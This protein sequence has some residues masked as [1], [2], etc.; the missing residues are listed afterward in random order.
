[1]LDGTR[2]RVLVY[3]VVMARRKP[4]TQPTGIIDVI[5][6]IVSPWLGTPPG[7]YSSVTQAQGL[8]R[9]AAETLDQTFA[10]GMIKAGVQGNKALA[11]Q[12]AVN[13]AA[14]GTGYIAGKAVQKALPLVQS[15][16][17]KEVGVHLSNVDKLR[18]IKFSAK[19]AG[20]GS[21]YPNVETNQ[22]YKYSPNIGF[23]VDEVTKKIIS[24]KYVYPPESSYD[25][26]RTVAEYYV[27]VLPKKNYAYITQ[28]PR[29][30]V[31]PKMPSWSN[32]QMVPKQKVTQKVP[33]PNLLPITKYDNDIASKIKTDQNF[34]NVRKV[35]YDALLKREQITQ[36]NLRSTLNTVRGV[37]GVGAQQTG[38]KKIKRR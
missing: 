4:T 7:Q 27:N 16:I 22:T 5:K 32:A 28:S 29:G 12:A 38:T 33:L 11:R 36:S 19:R 2:Q 13:A 30:Q 3:H 17:G 24:P 35:L 25:F 1:M 20:T 34:E 8:A 31:D 37:A 26:S 6:D 10:G 18:K 21:G 23:N 15:R 9:G 14:L